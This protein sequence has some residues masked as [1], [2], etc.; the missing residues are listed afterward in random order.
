MYP[1]TPGS[2]HTM[3]LSRVKQIEGFGGVEVRTYLATRASFD[4]GQPTYR[5]DSLACAVSSPARSPLRV[6]RGYAAVVCEVGVAAMPRVV[7]APMSS[8]FRLVII[9]D[10]EKRMRISLNR[11]G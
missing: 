3:A 10:F 6:G 7:L 11:T 2:A 9:W 8:S 4:H 5:D 1:S